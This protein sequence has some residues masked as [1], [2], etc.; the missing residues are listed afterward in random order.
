MGKSPTFVD[1]FFIPIPGEIFNDF[2]TGRMDLPMWGVYGVLLRQVDFETGIWRGTAYKISVAWNDHLELRTVQRTLTRLE[3]GYIK[4]FRNPNGQRGG[5]H[6]LLHNYRIRFGSL[7]GHYLD[8]LATTDPKHPV[9]RPGSIPISVE[10]EA[11]SADRD[12]TATP[13]RHDPVTTASGETSLPYS[14]RN[15][16]TCQSRQKEVSTAD[17]PTDS[18]STKRSRKG[19]TGRLSANLQGKIKEEDTYPF[20]IDDCKKRGSKHPFG[21]EERQAFAEIG[22]T[23]DLTSPLLTYDFVSAVTTVCDEYRGKGISPGNLCSKIIDECERAREGEI[24]SGFSGTGYYWPPDFQDHRNRL[25][26]G[27]RKRGREHSGPG[28]KEIPR[29][30]PDYLN[31]PRRGPLTGEELEE[32]KKESAAFRKKL[33]AISG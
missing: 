12:M 7:A 22:Y 33:E 13:P 18:V 4:A 24:A 30:A 27:E 29:N 17:P 6:I 10:A 28:P 3:N 9:Y 15:N 19:R 11:P 16:Q 31:E 32:F 26:A 8:A 1:D 23:P 25:R 20:W 21:D 5:Y 2:E 14:S